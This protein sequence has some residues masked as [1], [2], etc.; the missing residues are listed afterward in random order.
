MNPSVLGIIH[1]VDVSSTQPSSSD[2]ASSGSPADS[3]AAQ[4]AAT[5][6]EGADAD[7]EQQQQT[8]NKIIR[9]YFPAKP[10]AGN[11]A[12]RQRFDASDSNEAVVNTSTAHSGTLLSYSVSQ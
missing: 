8:N 7:V 2:D 10:S 4:H 3:H 5:A 1:L 12:T 11:N 6:L 9:I